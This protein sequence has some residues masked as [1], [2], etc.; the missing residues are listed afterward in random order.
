NPENPCFGSD[1][2]RRGIRSDPRPSESNAIPSPGFHRIRRIPVGSDKIQYWI[3]WDSMGSGGIRVWDCSTWAC[4]RAYPTQQLLQEN[5][6]KFWCN[7]IWPENSPDLNVAEHIGSVIRDE[8]ETK[9][10][11]ETRDSRYLEE[12]LKM[13]LSHVWQTWKLTLIYS[14]LFCVRTHL[15]YVQ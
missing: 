3:R 7:D 13:Y 12:T 9:M 5:D 1:E 4:M 15:A 11:S 6:I 8:V 2:I 10:L 14:E